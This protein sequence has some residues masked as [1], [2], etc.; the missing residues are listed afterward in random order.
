MDTKELQIL[1]ELKKIKIFSKLNDDDLNLLVSKVEIR[2]LRLGELL[3]EENSPQENFVY[4]YE[5]ALRVKK[6]INGK[7]TAVGK[8][9]A[10]DFFGEISFFKESLWNFTLASASKST[11]FIINS[12][13]VSLKEILWKIKSE[14]VFSEYSKKI[15]SIFNFDTI[16]DWFDDFVKATN[17]I[18]FED[19]EIVFEDGSLNNSLYLVLN[20]KVELYKS[21]I[22]G[23][24]L[25]GISGKDEFFGEIGALNQKN[26][27]YK[28]VS[29]G[30]SSIVEITVENLG[31][32]F[33][34]N[35]ILLERFKTRITELGEEETRL[36]KN[37]KSEKRAKEDDVVKFTKGTGKFP[38]LK[39]HDETDCGAACLTMISKYYGVNLSMGQ[40]REMANVS[41]SGATMSAVCRAAENLGYRARGLKSTIN[42]LKQ[43]NFPLIGHWQ[44]FH[45]IVIHK[46]SEKYV[47]V[48]DPDLGLKKYTYDYFKANWTGLV[49]ELEPTL[50]LQE[51]TPAK[52]PIFRFLAYLKPFKF[53]I[54][55][56]LLGA[57]VLNIL[58]LASPLF[59]Q[60][61]VDKVV[62]YKDV[63]LLNMMLFGMIL[64]A[65]F[66]TLTSGLQSLLGAHITAKMDFR[67]LAEFYRHVLSMPMK[68]FYQRKIGDIITRFG[69]N[70]KVRAILTNTIISL[71][72]N[73]IMLLVFTNIM[74]M[75]NTSL[76]ILVLLFVPFYI[77]QMLIFTPIFVKLSNQIFQVSSDQSSLMI[78]SIQGIET[79]KAN[80][81]EWNIRSKWENKYLESVNMSFKMNKLDLISS[82]ISQT[83]N[84]FSSISILW[85]GATQVIDGKMSIGELMAFNAIIGSVMGPLMGLVTLYND[86]QQVKTSMERLNDVLEAEPEEKFTPGD[87]KQKTILNNP[88]GEIEF[89]D[90]C[91]RYGD[92]DSPLVINNLNLTIKAGTS[93]AFVGQSGCGKST[94][95]K[96]VPGFLRP[97]SGTIL[98]DGIDING[99]ELNSLRKNI[100]WVLQD[101]FL[102]NAT[103]MENIALGYEKPDEKDVRNAADLAA[104]ADFISSFPH[105]YKTLIGEKGLQLSGGQRQRV[106]IARALFRNPKFLLFDEATSALDAESERIIQTNLAKIMKG[107]TSITIAHRLSTIRDCDMICYLHNGVIMEKGTHDELMQAGGL[108]HSMASQQLGKDSKS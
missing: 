94:L 97:S 73:I 82:V 34:S 23:D 40:V 31:L 28:A 8:Q 90:L 9:S 76:S 15:L 108:Y 99:I 63:T 104:A 87:T 79:I 20:G 56:I 98:I 35:S 43:L 33:N 41:T 65:F 2:N 18:S 14:I 100:G 72:L 55:E 3:F 44:G 70:A 30:K 22:E 75:Y 81:V 26:Q 51:V 60:V 91:F 54:F 68:F 107:R 24:I 21:F 16:P 32:I 49:I 37:L 46:L 39:Q 88:N 11:I 62:V 103:V 69:E 93:V 61:I 29:K 58:G 12:K 83:I 96:M 80:G 4:I 17:L 86:F 64:V 106:C 52:N 47:W 25:I 78:E 85:Y 53:F 95:L 1:D 89:R 74:F 66:S 105:G 77:G 27:Q 19:E 84:T 71:I 92:E 67:M 102:F 50:Q 5:G 13:D 59:T 57:F 10:G 6:D 7:V 45:Y 36:K 101:S 48:A 38:W 42:A